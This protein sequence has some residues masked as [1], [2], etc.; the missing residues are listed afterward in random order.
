MARFDGGLIADV[1]LSGLLRGKIAVRRLLLRKDDAGQ[2][3]EQAEG[4][5]RS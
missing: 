3:E 1:A 4:S 2:D 5:H